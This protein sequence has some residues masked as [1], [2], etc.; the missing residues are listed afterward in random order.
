MKTYSVW[1]E[2]RIDHSRTTCDHEL[3][4]GGA[5]REKIDGEDR[6]ILTHHQIE[7]IRKEMKK[8]LQRR[9]QIDQLASVALHLYLKIIM[10]LTQE[11]RK[12]VKPYSVE[13]LCSQSLEW[14]EIQLCSFN[15]SGENLLVLYDD[16]NSL[17]E[18]PQTLNLQN[19]LENIFQCARRDNAP[20]IFDNLSLKLLLASK[21]YFKLVTENKYPGIT[22]IERTG[23][24]LEILAAMEK[25]TLRYPDFVA[26][27]PTYLLLTDFFLDLAVAYE[28]QEFQSRRETDRNQNG[29]IVFTDLIKILEAIARI[30]AAAFITSPTNKISNFETFVTLK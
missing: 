29:K 15:N 18:Y 3:I 4:A 21:R 24:L 16:E 6:L 30:K 9:E 22:E 23:A 25:M 28:L 11:M 2:G 27:K 19:R 26:E 8:D 20:Q 1:H 17:A 5:N 12:A 13:Y 7:Q 14:I 10:Q